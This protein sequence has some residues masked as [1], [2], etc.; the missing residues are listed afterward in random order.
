MGKAAGYFLKLPEEKLSI[1]LVTQKADMVN[2]FTALITGTQFLN[3]D[4][5]ACS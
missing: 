4:G 5:Y 1:I 2:Y 3:I